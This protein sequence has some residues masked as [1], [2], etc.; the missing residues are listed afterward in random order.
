[1]SIVACLFVFPLLMAYQ[2][3]HSEKVGYEKGDNSWRRTSGASCSRMEAEAS[4]AGMCVFIFFSFLF[5][6]LVIQI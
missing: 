5:H 4:L 2:Q 6:F 1:M 3:Q